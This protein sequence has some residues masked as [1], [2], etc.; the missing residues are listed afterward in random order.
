[1]AKRIF[2]ILL[3]CLSVMT[4]TCFA[5]EWDLAAED[6]GAH[7]TYYLLSDTIWFDGTLGGARMKIGHPDNSYEICEFQ[8]LVRKEDT[9]RVSFKDIAA[10]DAGGRFKH[11]I[12]NDCHFLTGKDAPLARVCKFAINEARMKA[13]NRNESL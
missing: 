12:D 10:H 6:R 5:S 3:L 2:T 9:Y 13:V 8:F 1:M 7:E 4:A 11:Y